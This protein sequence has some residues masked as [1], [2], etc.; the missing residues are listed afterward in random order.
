MKHIKKTVVTIAYTLLI[1]FNT[2]YSNEN[3]KL[4]KSEVAKL[5]D[6]LIKTRDEAKIKVEETDARIAQMREEKMDLQ[7]D[8]VKAVKDEKYRFQDIVDSNNKL[9]DQ[10]RTGKYSYSLVV[11]QLKSLGT[12]PQDALQ[13]TGVRAKLL[14]GEKVH[15][16]L[17][18]I[19]AI[20]ADKSIEEL[21]DAFRQYKI[22]PKNDDR[23]NY[24]IT[25]LLNRLLNKHKEIMDKDGLRDAVAIMEEWITIFQDDPKLAKVLKTRV[26]GD[27]EKRTR[28]YAT[29]DR[30]KKE[31]DL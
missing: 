9:L 6:Y 11:A 23:M 8:A 2:V 10:L 26:V 18:E 20:S 25:D 16:L 3:V 29:I 4:T 22:G 21:N 30:I 27:P 15:P 1:G 12:N 13:A 24:I 31:H 14:A 28:A 5:K 19:D 17:I 7:S